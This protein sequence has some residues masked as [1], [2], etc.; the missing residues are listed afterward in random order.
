M[1]KPTPKQKEGRNI[2]SPEDFMGGAVASKAEKNTAETAPKTVVTTE[3]KDLTPRANAKGR[4]EKKETIIFVG[5]R[6]PES[7]AAMIEEYDQNYALRGESK[8]SIMGEGIRK[9]ISARLQKAKKQ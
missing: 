4:A 8:N 3:Q 9:E 2:F 1:P 5:V 6:I 7:T